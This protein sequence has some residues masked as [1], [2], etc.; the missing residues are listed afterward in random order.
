MSLKIF[1]N[2]PMSENI[3]IIIP[4]YNEAEN[5]S[6][7]ISSINKHLPKSHILVVDDN[8]PDQTSKIVKKLINQPKKNLFI[9]ERQNKTGLGAAY[10][11]GFKW[12]LEKKYNFI[13]EMDADFSHDPAELPKMIDLLKEGND[14]IIGSRYKEGVNVINWPLGRILLSYLAS[15][16][17][18]VI[19]GMPIKDPTAGYIGYKR[20]VLENI[21]LDKIK[22]LGYAFQI[23]MKYKSWISGY[24]LIEYPIIFKNRVRGKSKMDQSIFWEAIVSVIK[25]RFY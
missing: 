21:E 2:L 20:K 10:V 23:E 18:R 1:L 19:T 12:A 25:L 4:T 14:L 6:Q 22:S 13:F 3:L 15:F 16:Y 24:K 17:V 11:E 7:I 5:I 8:S 9:L